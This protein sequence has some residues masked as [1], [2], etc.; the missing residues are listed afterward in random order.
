[1]QIAEK[2]EKVF[3]GLELFMQ[4]VSKTRCGNPDLFVQSA[5]A[6]L[7]KAHE[8]CLVAAKSSDDTAYF[9][10]P[11]LRGI[12]EDYIVLRFISTELGDVKDKV[13]EL[14]MQDE[15]YQSSSAQWEFF[16]E[17]H[18]DQK[19]YFGDDFDVQRTNN[20]AA[21]RQLMK[22][23]PLRGKASMPTVFYMAEKTNLSAL[24]AYVYH[25]ASSLVHFNPRILL[26]MGWGDLPDITFSSR[27]FTEYY[28]HFSTFYGAYLFV[29]MAT[30]LAE[31]GTI[32]KDIE[33]TLTTIK[34]ILSSENRWPELVTFEEM[35]IGAL[36]RILF[37]KSPI[38]A[39]QKP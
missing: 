8:F 13:I 3:S 39:T 22:G 38:E 4:L 11:T 7:I 10:M 24:Y 37:Y 9:I 6:A 12:C 1:M 21:L 15:I 25:A 27:N 32:E 26:R 16:K 31:I 14:K 19:L 20:L 23:H 35:N 2:L 33:T 28:K 34:E 36:S 5:R 18:P 29:E 30:W 17:N